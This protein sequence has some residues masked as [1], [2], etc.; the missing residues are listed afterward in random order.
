M[1]ISWDQHQVVPPFNQTF[2]KVLLSRRSLL[3]N[4]MSIISSAILAGNGI[5]QLFQRFRRI[6]IGPDLPV[7]SLS[8]CP[9]DS[10]IVVK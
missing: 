2:G 1:L 7:F 9:T 3:Y 6:L 10:A 4:M 8:Q 5:L